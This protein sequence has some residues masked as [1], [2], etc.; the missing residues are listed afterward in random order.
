MRARSTPQ[1]LVARARIVLEC[2]K[3]ASNREVAALVGV[4]PATVGK[5][6]QRFVD[7]RLDGLYDEPKPGRN[8]TIDDE[9][10]QQVVKDTLESAPPDA[11]QWSTRSMADRAGISKAS[12]QRIWHTFGLKPH[13]QETF[14]IS[15][16]PFFVDKVHDV[17]GLYMAP[18]ENAMVVCVDE[19]SQIQA[20]E[21]SQPMLPMLPGGT[22]Q[23]RSHDYKRNGVTTLFAALDPATG[24]VIGEIHRRH[25]AVEFVKFL[26]TVYK[27]KPEGKSLHVICDNVSSHKTPAVKGWLQ[28]HPDVQMHFTPTYSS[29]LNMVEGWFAQLTNKLLKRSTHRTLQALEADLR[30]WIDTWNENPHPFVWTKTAEEIL[31]SL[32]SY[33]ELACAS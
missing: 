26:N 29:W 28:R 13:L 19:K 20:L 7:L 16:D 14:K 1:S 15:N 21:R 31:E 32:A 27:A 5:W 33:L 3:G 12:V 10:V 11:T 6:R 2:E 9:K 25:R 18:P 30:K 4:H 8:R 22:P 17:V 23:R 24:R